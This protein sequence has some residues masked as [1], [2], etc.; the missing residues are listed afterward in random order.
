M[1]FN[2]AKPTALNLPNVLSICRLAA[3][4]PLIY[5]AWTGRPGIFLACVIASLVSDFLDGLLARALNQVTDLGTRLDSWADFATTLAL[6][7]CAWWLWPEVIRRE[8]AFLIAALGTYCAAALFGFLKYRLLISYHT[9]AGKVAAVR[10]GP[11][12]VVLLVGGPA[13]PF[14]CAT[15]AFVLAA[16]EEMAI[17]ILLPEWRANVP[18]FWH[19][20]KT[21]R[22][23]RSAPFE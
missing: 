1:P 6:P 11:T 20:L 16:L 18:S 5:L 13:W 23:S 12:V 7:I 19:A 3:V 21:S 15:P 8:A 9:W 10:R 2:Q 17:T 4:P 22:P 14:E